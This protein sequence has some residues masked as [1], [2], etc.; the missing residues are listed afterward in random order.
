MLLY[1]DKNHP[2]AS[3]SHTRSANSETTPWA[4]VYRAA[5]G[6]PPPG[7]ANTSQT[8]QAGDTVFVKGNGA[9]YTETAV[10]TSF[11]VPALRP[12]NSGTASNPIRFQSFPGHA[13]TLKST[14]LH[15]VIGTSG[16]M[17]YIIW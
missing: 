6:A 8:A 2:N 4:T 10:G 3:D 17:D 9:T 14:D 15:P 11:N 1:V 13:V 5:R 16:G 7:A 12:A